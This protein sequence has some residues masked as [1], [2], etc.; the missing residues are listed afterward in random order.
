MR[1]KLQD[2]YAINVHVNLKFNTGI[3]VFQHVTVNFTV[4]VPKSIQF[5][6]VSTHA[7][8]AL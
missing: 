6:T 5:N 8:T 7:E 2:C 4:Y 3:K 1:Y